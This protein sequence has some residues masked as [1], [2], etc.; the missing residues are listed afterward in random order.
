QEPIVHIDRVTH[1]PQVRY[2]T[3]GVRQRRS[4]RQWTARRLYHLDTEVGHEYICPWRQPDGRMRVQLEGLAIERGQERRNQR[5]SAFRGQQAGGVLDV[6]PIDGRAVRH[7][8]G[9]AG[10]E[11]VVVYLAERV[12]QRG[13]HLAA[14]LLDGLRGGE[15]VRHLVHRVE[16]GE[17]RDPVRDETLVDELHEVWMCHLPRDESETGD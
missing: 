4:V 14:C 8:L 2:D 13:H 16:Q 11:G 12:D 5:T 10:V 17:P 6:D 7:L 9:E 15:Q 1:R 3:M